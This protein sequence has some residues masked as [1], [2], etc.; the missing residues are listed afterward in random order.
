MSFYICFQIQWYSCVV[1]VATIQDSSR[2]SAFYFRKNLQPARHQFLCC[3]GLLLK[4][5]INY[6]IWDQEYDFI[7]LLENI[8]LFGRGNKSMMYYCDIC[9]IMMG[10]PELYGGI[11]WATGSMSSVHYGGP[12]THFGQP[13]PHHRPHENRHKIIRRTWLPNIGITSVQEWENGRLTGQTL[14]DLQ[15]KFQFYGGLIGGGAEVMGREP[16]IG[17]MVMRLVF[18]KNT[19]SFNRVLHGFT[20]LESPRPEYGGWTRPVE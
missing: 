3:G 5:R 14:V 6:N 19:L 7:Q 13:S 17:K 20:S 4:D 12:R 9:L 10:E 18:S 16:G 15:I 11:T 8:Y 1:S 2:D